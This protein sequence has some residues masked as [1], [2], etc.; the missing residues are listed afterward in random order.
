MKNI[1]RLAIGLLIPIA[2]YSCSSDD[3]D[4]TGDGT[5]G[6]QSK[7][8]GSST[9][10]KATGGRTNTG[11]TVVKPSTGG[12]ANSSSS[13]T[14]KGGATQSG[15]G[16]AGQPVAGAAGRSIASTIGGALTGGAGGSSG[17]SATAGVAGITG[18]AGASSIAPQSCNALCGSAVSCKTACMDESFGYESSAEIPLCLPQTTVLGGL[19]TL[20]ANSTCSGNQRGC[21]LTI[22]LGTSAWKYTPEV[23]RTTKVQL[24][25]TIKGIKGTIDM[26]VPSVLDCSLTPVL[27]STGLALT[28]NGTVAPKSG[29]ASLLGVTV[30][31]I[32]VDLSKLSF[33]SANTTCETAAN[34]YLSDTDALT[35]ELLA[36]LQK[37][38]AELTCLECD[39]RCSQNIACTAPAL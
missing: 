3:E 38:A 20:C 14:S 25:T 11:T 36:A 2:L 5:G 31:G 21:A 8:G 19:V 30:S 4:D 37:R 27:P 39:S 32:A 26:S 18:L 13:A 12:T 17:A 16:A 1:L 33:S 23:N 15:G 7:G 9:G 34:G 6:E 10:T 22:V 29:N 24:D 28:A 35:Q